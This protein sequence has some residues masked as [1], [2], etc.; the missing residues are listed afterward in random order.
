M[1]GQEGVADGVIEQVLNR[2]GRGVHL[3]SDEQRIA[4]AIDA[5][6][7]DP[8]ALGISTNIEAVEAYQRPE[9]AKRM[10]CY[11]DSAID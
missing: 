6:L 1:G 8:N 10:W 2:T 9:I 3:G 5:L 4:D 11:L 7:G